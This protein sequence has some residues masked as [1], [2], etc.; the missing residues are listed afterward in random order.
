MRTV[1][2]PA[3]ALYGAFLGLVMVAARGIGP[4]AWTPLWIV[5]SF[6]LVCLAVITWRRTRLPLMTA[7]QSLAALAGLSIG[8]LGSREYE[9]LLLAH[10]VLMVAVFLVLPLLMFS[11]RWAHPEV[12]RRLRTEAERATLR[13]MLLLR[14][15]PDLRKL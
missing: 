11:E 3:A 6:Q 12:W 13:D 14:H 10:P 8:V 5:I 7:A 9:A 1:Q 2:M 4:A 15:I